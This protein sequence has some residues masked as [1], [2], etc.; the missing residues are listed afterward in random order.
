MHWRVYCLYS[1]TIKKYYIGTTNDLERRIAEHNTGTEQFTKR[2]TP[3]KLV[4]YILCNSHE[5]A[6]RLERRLKRGK[7]KKYTV[8]YFETRGVQEKHTGW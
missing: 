2:G 3:W 6:A 4:G 8:W 1:E 7:N 5:E